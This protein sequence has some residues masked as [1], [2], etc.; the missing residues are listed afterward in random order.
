MSATVL[1][2][3][4]RFDGFLRK[5]VGPAEILY[6]AVPYVGIAKLPSSTTR[7]TT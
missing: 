7:I 4:N 6:Q 2:C 3:G 5:V 1:M